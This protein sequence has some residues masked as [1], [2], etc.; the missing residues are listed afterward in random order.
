MKQETNASSPPPMAQAVPVTMS[1]YDQQQQSSTPIVVQ[2]VPVQT[3]QSADSA[4]ICKSCGRAFIRGPDVHSG[5][6]QWFRCD[7]CNRTTIANFCVIL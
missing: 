4:P 5:Q 2:S 7:E 6:A 1:S 3:P